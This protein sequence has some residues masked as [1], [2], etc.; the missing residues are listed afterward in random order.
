MTKI[1]EAEI[2]GLAGSIKTHKFKLDNSL[3]VFWGLN[4]SGKTSFLRILQSALANDPGAISDVSFEFA[5]V[6]FFSENYNATLERTLKREAPG[7]RSSHK[8]PRPHDQR[9]HYDRSDHF[10]DSPEGEGWVTRV[11]EGDVGPDY[12]LPYQHSFL[13]ISRLNDIQVRRIG[14]LSGAST[15]DVED[16][17]FEADIETAWRQ[18]NSVSLVK[19]REIQQK[20]L[21]DILSVLFQSVMVRAS[22]LPE[23]AI[24][25]D[26]AYRLVL[27]FLVQQ[28]MQLDVDRAA[29]MKR[30]RNQK[31]L[32]SVVHRIRDV[33]A[34]IEKA[35]RSQLAF[36][37]TIEALYSG[38]KK[39][40]FTR[41]SRIEVQ[42]GG[43]RSISVDRLSSGEKQL[44]RIL[45]TTLA[46]ESSPVMVDEPELSMH[47]DWQRQLVA[48]MQAV[49]PDCQLILATH[50]PE[51]VARVPEHQIFE[52]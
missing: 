1:I 2:Q 8:A 43:R 33:N 41:Y 48:C 29:F 28:G 39:I 7:N 27:D 47:I 42:A 30:Y 50:S 32:Q 3:N 25:E 19:I 36:Q 9:S 35:T 13:P 14:R 22:E 18:Y 45:L 21:A 23:T 37:K 26:D 10:E 52:L 12:E 31:E 40:R 24:D 20:G 15:Y 11:I 5:R 16:F 17:D 49:N 34:D 6:I 46:G 38:D 51:V 4:G 44:L